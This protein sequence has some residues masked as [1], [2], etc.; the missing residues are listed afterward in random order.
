MS[1]LNKKGASM[2]FLA[3]IKKCTITLV[4]LCSFI[5]TQ[6]KSIDKSNIHYVLQKYERKIRN[7]ECLFYPA[8][9]PKRLCIFFTGL[10]KN[11]YIMW[12]WFWDQH[13]NWQDTAYLFIKDDDAC[14]YLGNH[15]KS[16]IDDYSAIIKHFMDICKLSRK[17]VFAI[18][19][20]MGGYA[21][22]F[23]ATLL[24]LRAVIAINPQVQKANQ[25]LRDFSDIGDRWQELEKFVKSSNYVPDISLIY[26]RSPR[27]EANGH[28]LLNVLKNKGSLV[29]LRRHNSPHHTG[30]ANLTK[31]FVE[32]E[33][34]YFEN[35]ESM[36]SATLKMV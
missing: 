24:Q 25:K 26:S 31:K 2:K 19:G 32:S 10:K 16:F 21:A 20:S 34:A 28:A 4:L 8:K 5:S 1:S 3:S 29:I 30:G 7:R 33:I 14:W 6:V 35:Q 15:K 9:N 13:E 23:Y 11:T 22:I 27:D 18:G 12:S 36:N 17:N